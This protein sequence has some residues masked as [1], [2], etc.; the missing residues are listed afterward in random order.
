M[1]AGCQRQIPILESPSI[2]GYEV[3]GTVTDQLGNPIPNV[4]VY[5]D[6][7]WETNYNDTSAT[8]TYFVS[9]PT[10]FVSADVVDWSG[11]IVR[12]LA[13][14]RQRYG[15][16]EVSWNG[17]DTTGTLVPSGLYYVQYL[18]NGVATFAYSQL[19]TGG[20]VATTDDQGHYTVLPPN[21]PVDS[22]ANFYFFPADSSY[23][24]NLLVLSDVVLTYTYPNHYQ[25]IQR[26][27]DKNL[28][29][30]VNVVFH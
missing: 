23:G 19:V 30:I 1:I 11:R 22:T 4:Q 6:Y 2:S 9:D 17:K 26:R 5:V 29:T 16:F 14:P 21:L 3:Q 13:S 20:Q 18:V 15:A 24:A 12:I 10:A 7:D 8:R 27:L 28:V 25:Q